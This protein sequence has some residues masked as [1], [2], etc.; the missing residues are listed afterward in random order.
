VQFDIEIGGKQ[1]GRIVFKLY[2]AEVPKT[3]ANFRQLATGEHG[4]GYAGSGFHRIIPQVRLAPFF[5]P[6][7]PPPSGRSILIGLHSS[8]SRAGTSPTTTGPAGRASTARSS[9]VRLYDRP[10]TIH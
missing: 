9:R 7:I 4:F 1:A 6:P 5:M 10:S 8:C 2:D 3:A